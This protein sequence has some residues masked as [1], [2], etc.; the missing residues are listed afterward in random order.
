MILSQERSYH[1]KLTI[2]G[3]LFGIFARQLLP[4]AFGVDHGKIGA[5][6]L[7]HLYEIEPS[8]VGLD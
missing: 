2:P 1:V 5:K 6:R 4:E 8:C 3:L 7:G